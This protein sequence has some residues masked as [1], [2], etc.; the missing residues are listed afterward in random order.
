M[1]D[2]TKERMRK[3]L[4]EI[5]DIEGATGYRL[6]KGRRWGD[7]MFIAPPISAEPDGPGPVITEPPFPAD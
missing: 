7:W 6:V 5:R 4:N 2:D 1:D 3:A